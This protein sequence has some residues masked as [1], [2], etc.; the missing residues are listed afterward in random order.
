M[1]IRAY[2]QV[3]EPKLANCPTF[4][5]SAEFY[6]IDSIAGWKSYNEDNEIQ[7]IE[8]SREEIGISL[9]DPKYNKDQKDILKSIRKDIGKDDYVLYHCY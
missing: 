2:K 5:L 1:S 6:W 9:G 7:S 4:N 3:K 8:F